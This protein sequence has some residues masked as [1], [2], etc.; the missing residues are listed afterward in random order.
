[1]RDLSLISKRHQRYEN[2]VP[3]KDMQ[4][5]GRALIIQNADF[6]QM[7]DGMPVSPTEG[8]VVRMIN[9]DVRD[10][11]GNYLEMM[12]PKLMKLVS[13][14]GYKMELR[15]VTLRFMDTVADYSD[16]SITLHLVNRN[17]VKCVLHILD[18]GIDLEY[19]IQP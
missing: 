8:F 2:G 1:M 5:C 17:V 6:R 11:N 13:D 18:R 10:V 19:D 9:T 7:M 3:V 16:Y 14:T 4:Y 15:G 12:Q